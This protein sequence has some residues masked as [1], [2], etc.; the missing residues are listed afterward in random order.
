[1]DGIINILKPPNMTSQDVVSYVKK[2]LNVKKAGHTGTLDPGAAGVLPVCI[3]KATRISEYLMNDKKTYR[4][5]MSIGFKSNTLDKYGDI[6][7]VPY[8]PEDKDK[9]Y[10]A[11]NNFRGKI[12]QIPPMFS[13]VKVKGKKLYELARSGITIDR[14]PR[15]IFIYSID[16]INVEGNNILFDVTCSKGTYIRTLC[17]DIGKLLSSDAIMTFLLRCR[18]GPFTLDNSVTLFELEQYVHENNVEAVLFP[19][20][21]ALP[22][23]SRVYIDDALFCKVKN[24]VGFH[25]NEAL[26]YEKRKREDI[27]LI[28]NR[29]NKFAAVG[30]I[31]A[32]GHVKVKK[33]FLR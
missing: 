25:I 27:I 21:S 19:V 26:R 12:E 10:D 29:C 1:M 8:S 17:S 15:S 23:C 2:I 14:A 22:D 16:I 20:E 31:D 28:F 33:V 11:F 5:E 18:T 3:G 13:A 30:A 6:E 4:T 32:E 9:I 7:K 24:G